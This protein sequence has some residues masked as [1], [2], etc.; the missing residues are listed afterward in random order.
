M[1]PTTTGFGIALLSIIL[2][3]SLATPA[4]ESPEIRVKID[5]SGESGLDSIIRSYLSREL[6][7][8]PDVAIVDSNPTFT[9][10]IV[11]IEVRTV[12]REHVGYALSFAVTS[13]M[14]PRMAYLLAAMRHPDEDNAVLKDLLTTDGILT[15][16]LIQTCGRDELQS[17]LAQVAAQLDGGSFEEAR[18]LFQAFKDQRR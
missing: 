1:K 13:V 14:K 9:V 15:N 7:K 3:T 2:S 12:T 11:G 16:H 17:V 5:I 8:V 4:T 18:S 6:R 10:S